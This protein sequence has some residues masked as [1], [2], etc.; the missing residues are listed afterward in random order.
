MTELT[1]LALVMALAFVLALRSRDATSE[2]RL[3]VSEEKE[4][5]MTL[6][7]SCGSKLMMG[8][9]WR[10]RSRSERPAPTTPVGVMSP[11]PP[12]PPSNEPH[13]EFDPE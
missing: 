11:S 1:L 3:R 12:L 9:D 8:I 4:F 6:A 2:D 7:L 5:R 10:M 13:P